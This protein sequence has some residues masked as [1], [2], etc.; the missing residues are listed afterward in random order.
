MTRKLSLIA[1]TCFLYV[2]VQA[3]SANNLPRV[4]LNLQDAPIATLVTAIEKQTSLFFYFDKV[5]FDSVRFNLNASNAPIDQVLD[6]AFNNTEFKYAIIVE[7]GSVM[8]TRGVR[9]ASELPA[10]FFARGIRDT[11]RQ[12]LPEYG[13]RKVVKIDASIENKVF[14]IG[15]K[16]NSGSGGKTILA[17]YVRDVKTGE[18]IPGVSLFTTS[19]AIGTATDQ[20]GYYSLTLPRGRHIINI[21]ALGMKDTRRQVIMNSDGKFDI[22]MEERIISLKEVIVSAQKLN[23]IRN[24]QMGMDRLNIKTIKQVPALFGESDILRVVLTLPGVKTAGEASTGFNV[25]G[26]STDQNL[27]LFNDA[28]IYNPSHF[29]GFFSAFNPDVVKDVELYKSSVPA[30]YGGRLSS[31]LDI[32]SREGNK[33]EITG[34]AGLGIVT[35]RFNIEGPLIKDKTSFIFGARA[36]YAN[37]LLKLLPAEYENSKAGFYDGN[38]QISHQFNQKSNLY[39]NGYFS[40]DRFSL[41]SDTTFSYSNRNFSVKFKHSFN[42]KWN[43]SVVAGFDGYEY[44][45][46]SEKDKINAH[47]LKF[48]IQ[49][50]NFKADFTHYINAN[51]T[52]EF[53]LS[54]I[55]YKLNPGSYQPKNEESLII[56]DVLQ[57]EHAQESAVYLSDR[58]N[59]TPDLSIQGGIRYSYYNF[60]GP[61]DIT[62]YAPG[63]PKE[64]D[65]AIGTNSFA[66]GKFIKTYH[67]PEYRLGIRY[68]LSESL[69]LKAGYNSLRQYIHMLSNTTAISPTDIWKLSDPNIRPQYGDQFSLGMYKNFKNN[70]IE[71]SLE[72]YYK[73]IKDYLDY[74]SGAELIMN[75]TIETDVIN[76]KGKAYGIELMVKKPTGKLNGWISYTYSRILLKQD[77]PNAGEVI[78]GGEYYPA[79][80]DKPHDLTVVSNYRFTH[81]FSVSVTGSYSTGRPITVPIGRYYFGGSQRALFADRNEYRIPDYFRMDLSFNLDGNHKIKQKQA[82]HN[83]WAFGLYNLTGRRNPYSVYFVS[84]NGFINGYRLSIFGSII[85]FVN[86]TIRF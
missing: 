73:R 70:T 41:N 46:A 28:T 76:T 14:D 29:F 24:P 27:I 43:A 30:K 38:L 3:Q 4:T 62:T 44:Q 21:Q 47:E 53:G 54:T 58:W 56:P 74:K 6:Q 83:S 35:S 71:T 40:R 12:A 63:L 51:H 84:E 17:G 81:R 61:K 32:S 13:D 25:R 72:V 50:L 66:S 57:S 11:A 37:W 59:I 7:D 85:P 80:Y 69:S 20:Y 42:N 1:I 79:N 67:G 55:N 60:L 48:D 68:S 26:G 34:S 75:H 52:L 33:K 77:D 31:V 65:N 10:D 19:T 49:Q 8:L 86:Y 64:P 5:Q 22:L 2:A 18:P 78:N 16:T 9:I 15:I 82:T 23:N 39:I 45:I 36:T